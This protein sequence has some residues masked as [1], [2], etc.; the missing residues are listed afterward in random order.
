MVSVKEDFGNNVNITS[1][2]LNSISS[3]SGSV[4]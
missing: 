2:K 3:D 4:G 1:E